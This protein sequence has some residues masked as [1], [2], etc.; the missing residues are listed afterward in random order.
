[1]HR[2]MVINAKLFCLNKLIFK[3]QSYRLTQRIEVVFIQR[4]EA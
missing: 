2:K 1:M 4:I 3:K